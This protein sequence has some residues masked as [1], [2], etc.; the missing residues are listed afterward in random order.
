[1]ATSLECYKEGLTRAG[2]G[3]RGTSGGASPSGECGDEEDPVGF[4]MAY[5]L[6]LK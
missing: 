6:H 3:Q 4:L 2:K 1:M 5:I